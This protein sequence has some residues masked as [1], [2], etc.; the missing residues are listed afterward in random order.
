[1]GVKWCLFW[2]YCENLNIWL[3]PE[4]LQVNSNK[5][6]VSG[7]T[8]GGWRNTTLPHTTQFV[9]LPDAG[10]FIICRQRVS[11]WTDGVLN[12]CRAGEVS[13]PLAKYQ[14]PTKRHLI[15]SKNLWSCPHWHYK[16][17]GLFNCLHTYMYVRQKQIQ[18]S[19]CKV[20]AKNYS[21]NWNITVIIWG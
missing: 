14:K 13:W 4:G 12:W 20:T 11:L 19:Q 7:N 21:E 8:M 17:V 5:E 16:G 3:I 2:T 1:M 10:R 9:K 15:T 18:F 6:T